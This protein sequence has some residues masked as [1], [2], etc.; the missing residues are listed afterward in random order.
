MQIIIV[1]LRF[2]TEQTSDQIDIAVA[3]MILPCQLWVTV[4]SNCSKLSHACMIVFRPCRRR[5]LRT[6]EKLRAIGNENW[7]DYV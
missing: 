7:V 6:R 2:Q 1:G 3:K 5:G 4:N